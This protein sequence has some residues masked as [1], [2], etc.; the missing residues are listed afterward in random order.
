MKKMFAIKT[1]YFR[2]RKATPRKFTLHP[3]GGRKGE[4]EISNENLNFFIA[5]I[6]IFFYLKFNFQLQKFFFTPHP[7]NLGVWGKFL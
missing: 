7:Y 2:G 6:R 3:G 5:D 1:F 4:I